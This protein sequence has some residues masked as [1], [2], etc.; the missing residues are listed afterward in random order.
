MA[1]QNGR[2]TVRCRRCWEKGHNIRNC[3]QNTPEQKAA[4]TDGAKARTCSY[5]GEAKHNRTSC[6]KR[7]ADKVAYAKTNADYRRTVL[8]TM[9][10]QGLGIGAL[11]T[12]DLNSNTAESMYIITDIDWDLVQEKNATARFLIGE[13]IGKDSYQY[14]M[15]LARADY[16]YNWNTASVISRAKHP[17]EAP[18][19][20]L[21]GESGIDKFFK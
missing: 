11:V 7:K 15:A 10:E 18:L 5:C 16:R 17:Q 6:V 14:S 20:W 21:N 12:T 13:S 3:P 1:W 8:A 19:G 4:Y 2:R 9:R